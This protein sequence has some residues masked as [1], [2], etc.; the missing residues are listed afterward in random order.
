MMKNDSITPFLKW[1]G[2]KRQLL[3][4]I[5]ALLP[6]H[7]TSYCEP[8]LG[9]GAIL[10]FIRPNKAIVNDLNDDLIT[11]YE[12]V[13]DDLD[14]L[15]KDLERHENTS[16]YYY[17]IRN[18]DRTDAYKSMTKVQRASRFLYL[19]RTCFNGLFRVNASGQFNVPFGKYKIQ[20]S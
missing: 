1:A 12:A 16:E 7:I 17:A 2:G 14:F 13:R 19:N 4:E 20:T 18:L 11:T 8:F 3:T 9:G 5:G 6:E 10:F 15:I